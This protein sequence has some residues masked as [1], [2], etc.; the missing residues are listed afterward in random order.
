[1]GS[2]LA[3]TI[4]QNNH[5]FTAGSVVRWNSGKDGTTADYRAAQANTAY[6]AEVVGVVSEVI[7]GN[8]FELTLGG[9][10]KMNSFFSNTTGTIPAG[11]TADDVYFLS[12]HTAGW[13]DIER[14]TTP[15]WVAKPVITRIAEDTDGNIFGSVTNYVGSLLGGNIAT[16]LGQIVPVGTMH[17]WLGEYNKVPIGWALCDGAGK[18]DSNGV[19]GIKVSSYS[20]YYSTVGKEYGWIECLKTADT[21]LQSGDRIKQYVS[22]KNVIGTVVGSSGGTE[23]DGKRY[24]FVRQSIQDVDLEELDNNL[25]SENFVTV[26]PNDSLRGGEDELQ[27]VKNEGKHY[28]LAPSNVLA[29]FGYSSVGTSIVIIKED[30]EVLDGASLFSDSSSKVG[31]FSVL[32]PDLRQRFALGGRDESLVGDVGGPDVT[33]NTRGNIGGNDN[34]DTNFS[35]GA[36]PDGINHLMT[37]SDY[38]R[39]TK[40]SIM[41]PYVTVNWIV[42]IDPNASAAVIDLLEIKDLKLTDLPQS[43]SGQD[44]YTIW[45]DDGNLKIVE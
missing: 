16:S 20:E 14:P 24:I 41:P 39:W 35:K 44:Q 28:Y 40:Q 6:N 31:V 23:A 4:T 12:G 30:G 22:G 8:S 1:V 19:E 15:G 43:T 11:F 32:P 27:Q 9:I 34:F 26:T 21:G 2:K 10:L 36:P 33:T 25:Y 42:R 37:E 29:E 7:S 13:M 5:G 38:S 18:K 45:N 17:A 3:I